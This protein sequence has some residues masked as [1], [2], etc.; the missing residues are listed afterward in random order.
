[1]SCR[2]LGKEMNESNR[3]TMQAALDALTC[4]DQ[5][6]HWCPHCDEYVDRNGEVKAKLRAALAE[7]VAALEADIAQEPVAVKEDADA[8]RYD[9]LSIA[10][11]EVCAD[12]SIARN[13]LQ[14]MSQYGQ[15]CFEE[16]L[17]SCPPVVSAIAQDSWTKTADALPT[18]ETPVL[19]LHCGKPRIGQRVWDHPGYEDTYKAYWYWDDPEDDGQGWDNCDITHWMPLPAAPATAPSVGKET[20]PVSFLDGVVVHPSYQAKCDRIRE[21][22]DEE[23]RRDA[24]GEI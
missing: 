11:Y 12:L 4:C 3:A 15:D 10:Y 6:Q 18:E 22:F 2:D 19:I 8:Q 9:E 1:M 13:K 17:A 5:D 16:G 23:M 20:E 21:E 14:Q 24:F 7:P